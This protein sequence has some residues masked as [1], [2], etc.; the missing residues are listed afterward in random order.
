MM[1]LTYQR[2]YQFLF[3]NNIISTFCA[4]NRFLFKEI[5][6]PALLNSRSDGT[7]VAMVER[8]TLATLYINLRILF[9][10]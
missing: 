5:S 7:D 1:T 2:G 4:F 6:S 10:P 9:P 8:Y 3:K